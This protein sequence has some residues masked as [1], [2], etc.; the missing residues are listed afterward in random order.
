MSRDVKWKN[1]I[2]IADGCCCCFV[3][4][5][6]LVSDETYLF[7]F[8]QES[9]FFQTTDACL[10]KI[11]KGWRALEQGLEPWT[12]KWEIN[13]LSLLLLLSLIVVS[14]QFAVL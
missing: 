6:C 12:L 4:L 14:T 5:F 2:I 3:F 1:K 13:N 11:L 7:I 10:Y 9:L 8:L